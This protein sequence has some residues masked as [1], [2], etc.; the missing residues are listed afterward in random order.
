[1]LCS[2]P[3][4]PF[5]FCSRS[6]DDRIHILIPFRY[7]IFFMLIVVEVRSEFAAEEIS[8]PFSAI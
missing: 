7:G 4:S 6:T 8:Y 1:M 2:T 5:A 3:I